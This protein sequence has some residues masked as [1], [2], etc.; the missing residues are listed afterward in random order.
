MTTQNMRK[1]IMIVEGRET[2]NPDVSY[3]LAGST[4]AKTAAETS[5]ET[6]GYRNVE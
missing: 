3:A 5:Q 2:D 6:Y 4:K 1:L